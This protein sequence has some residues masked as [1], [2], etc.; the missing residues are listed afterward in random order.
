VHISGGTFHQSPIGVG[1]KIS[2]TVNISASSDELFS[3]LREEIAALHLLFFCMLLV[4]TFYYSDVAHVNMAA[5]KIE[6]QI[7]VQMGG[8]VAHV[9]NRLYAAG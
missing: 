3:R 6:L 8:H 1:T 9:N 5:N 7:S 4:S 2:Q